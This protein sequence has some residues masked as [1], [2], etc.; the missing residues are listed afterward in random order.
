MCWP[1]PR[2]RHPWRAQ[3]WCP[4]AGSPYP[5]GSSTFAVA[6]GDFNHDHRADLAAP[7]EG[8]DDVTVLLGRAGGGYEEAPG[9][10]FS[11]G[12]RPADVVAADFNGD[13]RDD[14]AVANFGA[15]ADG[16]TVSV[17]LAQPDGGL[18]EE[19]GSP[20]HVG[21]APTSVETE[22][23]NHDGRPDLA[24]TAQTGGVVTILLR[25]AGGGF[26]EED[27]SPVPA[28]SDPFETAI[29]DF[30]RDKRLDLAVTD[31]S[32]NQVT[33]LL[34]QPGGGFAE[35]PESPCPRG[36]NRSASWPRTSTATA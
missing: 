13:G 22:D 19:A 34:R 14:V 7:A 16:D 26:T 3:S 17:L 32:S 36:H 30:N 11:V 2:S 18:S 6:V 8:S 10:P 35:A 27:G 29:G 21:T 25:D 5:A 31:Q 23:F 4:E 28:G 24:V 33:I 9:S 15:D 12:D 20:L 1:P